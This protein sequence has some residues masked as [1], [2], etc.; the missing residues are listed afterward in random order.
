MGEIIEFK[1]DHGYFFKKGAEAIAVGKFFDAVKNVRKAIELCDNLFLKSSYYLVLAQ[2]YSKLNLIQ[3]SNRCYFKALDFDSFSQIAFLGLGENFYLAKDY[4]MAQYYLNLCLRT[5]NEGPVIEKANLI[6]KEINKSGKSFRVIKTDQEELNDKYLNIAEKYMLK[7]NFDKAIE[8]FLLVDEKIL[9][10]K[11]RNQLRSGLSFAYFFTG[12][13]DKGIELSESV[14]NKTTLDLCNLLLLYYYNEETEKLESVKME[15]LSKEDLSK[16]DLYKI[17]ISFAH[18]KDHKVAKEYAQK[19]LQDNS[20]AIEIE[21]LYAIACINCG[22]KDTAK[23]KLLTLL[24]LDPENAYIYKKYLNMCDK[25]NLKELDYVF[26][27]QYGE[28]VRVGRTI[29]NWLEADVDLLDKLATENVDFLYYI[30]K[31]ITGKARN[32]L[33]LKLCDIDRP[34]LSSFFEDVLLDPAVS[35]TQ[36]V[37][38]MTRRI[39]NYSLIKQNYVIDDYYNRIALPSTAM[40]K[41]KNPNLFLAVILAS[42]FLMD[43][44]LG[45]NLNLKTEVFAVLKALEKND[46]D[47][48]KYILACIIVWLFV[49]EK[50]WCELRV[51]CAHFAITEKDLIDALE[52][53]KIDSNLMV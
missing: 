21:H 15:I 24:T 18:I 45:G 6:L 48:N 31:H 33:L 49:R 26:G 13:T 22:E 20:F 50:R 38:I 7:G 12:N 5:G 27:L 35:K 17:A 29:N 8:N 51:I 1:R 4:V 14:D 11:Q 32:L 52:K 25:Q 42:E 23:A 41:I 44:F 10:E 40:M 3:I 28:Y 43:K 19:V 37:Q 16:E 9:D 34:A 46:L 39:S 30:V 47:F 53:L 36:K 2:A